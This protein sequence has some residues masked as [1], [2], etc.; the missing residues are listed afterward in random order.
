MELSRLVSGIVQIFTNRSWPM[1]QIKDAA[2]AHELKRWMRHDAHR[3]VRPDWRRFVRPGFEKDHPFALYERKY[4]EDQLRDDRG[5][6]ADEG[7]GGGQ[8]A[9]GADEGDGNELPAN[10][11]PAHF[12]SS[13]V[14]STERPSTEKER[15]DVDEIIGKAKQLAARGYSGKYLMCLNLCYPLLERAQPKGSDINEWAYRR[16]IAACMGK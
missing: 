9:G 4:R 14:G 6:W 7:G 5:R 10:A 11:K 1:A 8:D 2:L 16:C 3:F 13:Q 15:A 12:T